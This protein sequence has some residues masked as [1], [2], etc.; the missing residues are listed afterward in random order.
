MVHVHFGRL[1][2]IN[3]NFGTM[4]EDR[5]E[6]RSGVLSFLVG[7][8]SLISL[9]GDGAIYR[10]ELSWYIILFHRVSRILSARLL[11]E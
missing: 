8:N 6:E 7:H 11:F 1:V 4:A 5:V 9:F 10:Y 3:T 2:S